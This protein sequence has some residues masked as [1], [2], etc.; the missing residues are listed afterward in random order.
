[1]TPNKEK[2]AKESPKKQSQQPTS[3]LTDNKRRLVITLDDDRP[4]T[5]KRQKP[6]DEP[7]FVTDDYNGV[8]KHS[9]IDK[10]NLGSEKESPVICQPSKQLLNTDTMTRP[11]KPSEAHKDGSINEPKS[12]VTSQKSLQAK[13]KKQEILPENLESAPTSKIDDAA[14]PNLSNGFLTASRETKQDAT[15]S[16][17]N[18]RDQGN[19]TSH[20]SATTTKSRFSKSKSLISTQ[21]NADKQIKNHLK[22]IMTLS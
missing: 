4:E 14:G 6:L 16:Q 17:Q 10:V 7:T 3:T 21:S 15:T 9:T 12:T 1:V 22:A 18:S 13:Q 11:Q 2:S 8:S 19:S 5:A 20:V